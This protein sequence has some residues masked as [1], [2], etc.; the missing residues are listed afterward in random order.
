MVIS[1]KIT[2]KTEA[3]EKALKQFF[4]ATKGFMVRRVLQTELVSEQPYS[5]NVFPS[6]F[7]AGTLKGKDIKTMQRTKEIIQKQWLG[8]YGVKDGIDYEVE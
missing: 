4:T 7:L 8:Q 6:Q 2:A 1:F 3:G 5:I